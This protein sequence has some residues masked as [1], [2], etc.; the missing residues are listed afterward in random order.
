MTGVI[1]RVRSETGWVDELYVYKQKHVADI[2]VR[3]VVHLIIEMA[4]NRVQ[5]QVAAAIRGLFSLEIF[6]PCRKMR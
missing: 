5:E 6:G 4:T 1:G 3:A 2:G